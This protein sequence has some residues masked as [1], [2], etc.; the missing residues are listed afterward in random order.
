MKNKGISVLIWMV[1]YL[2]VGG[3]LVLLLFHIEKNVSVGTMLSYIGSYSSI[4]GLFVMLIQFKSVRKTTEETKIKIDG[5]SLISEWSKATEL[6]R[7]VETDIERDDISVAS[8]KLRRVKDLVIQSKIG[9]GDDK[10]C[11]K[12]IKSLNSYISILN[13]FLLSK[14]QDKTFNKQEILDGLESITDVLN[15]KISINKE[16]L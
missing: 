10:E 9:G 6:I 2:L 16:T 4:F 13:Q 3:A 1:L 7:G 14:G 8:F 15:R 5:I 11:E 12:A